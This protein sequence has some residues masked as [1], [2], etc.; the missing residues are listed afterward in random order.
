MKDGGCADVLGMCKPVPTYCIRT[1]E[2]EE[3]LQNL[4]NTLHFALKYNNQSKGAWVSHI[5]ICTCTPVIA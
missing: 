4:N 3:K 5:Q 2:Y 1:Q